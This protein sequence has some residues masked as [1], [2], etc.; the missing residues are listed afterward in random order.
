M[1]RKE[2]KEAARIAA[3]EAGGET[4]KVTIICLIGVVLCQV[5]RV[6]L[7]QLFSNMG[8][9]STALSQSITAGARNYVLSYGSSIVLQAV[10][11]LLIA[12]YTAVALDLRQKNPV[13]MGTLLAGFRMIWRVILMYVLMTVFTTLWSYVFAF[14]FSAV[15]SFFVD[16]ENPMESMAAMMPYIMAYVAIV[17][18]LVSYRYRTAWF[19]LMD[20]PN[21]TPNQALKLATLINRGH[22]FRIFL[23]DLSFVP[24]F[25]L[26]ILTCGALLVWKLP[27][28]VTAYAMAYDRMLRQYAEKQKAFQEMHQRLLNQNN[29]DM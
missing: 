4:K 5:L 25:L 22:R 23:L 24:T 17:M 14:P 1:N 21:L 26:C 7:A 27:E 2:M 20:Q 15:L 12:G 18:F 16:V 9:D 19:V 8:G 3:K 10:F 6:V 28:I 11:I 29:P 13:G